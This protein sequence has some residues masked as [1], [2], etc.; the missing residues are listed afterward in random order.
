MSSQTALT[1]A[2]DQLASQRVAVQSVAL[3]SV[4]VQRVSVQPVVDYGTVPGY[5][6]V[7]NAGLLHH[8]GRYHLFARAIRDGYWRNEGPGPRFHDYISDIIVFTSA[9]GHDYEFGYVLATAD[10][11]I[12]SFEDPR[13]QTVM[14][15]GDEHIVMTYTRLPPPERGGPWRIGAHR[16]EYRDGRFHLDE[17]SSRHLGP[18]GVPNKDAVVFPLA[19]GRVALMHRIHPNMQVAVFDDLNH[20]WHA[21]DAYWDDHLAHLDRHTI[22]EPGHG[23]SG[24]G[25]GAP[26]LVTEQ[27]LLLFFHERSERGVYTINVALLDP[28]TAQVIAILPD[29]LMEPELPWERVGDVDEVVFV[30]G[31]H[32]RSD[33]SIYLT[34]GAADRCVGAVTVDERAL[35]DALVPLV[36]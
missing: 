14:H 8:D 9:D 27:G 12:W 36:A 25:A 33:G 26:P 13:V 2:V 31:V 21:D 1:P 16:L 3:Q 10:D 4:A 5:G 7:F 23:V 34:Y 6:P 29:A 20:L 30:Q 11:E 19:D 24:V 35:L 18:D 15:N 17:A 22:I 28:Y 32:R